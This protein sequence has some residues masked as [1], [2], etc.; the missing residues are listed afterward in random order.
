MLAKVAANDR[1]LHAKRQQNTVEKELNQWLVTWLLS[2]IRR[3]GNKR[4]VEPR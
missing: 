3:D 1:D 2:S 4:Q